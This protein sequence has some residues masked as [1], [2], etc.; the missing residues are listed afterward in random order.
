MAYQPSA[1]GYPGAPGAYPQPYGAPYGH[2]GGAPQQYGPPPGYPQAGP[3]AYY[4]AAPAPPQPGYPAQPGYAPAPGYPMQQPQPYGYPPPQQYAPQPY[5][6]PPYQA[7]PAQA[8]G[9]PMGARRLPTPCQG[10]WAGLAVCRAALPVRAGLMHAAFRMGLGWHRALSQQT[11][12]RAAPGRG[13]MVLQP[14]EN[15]AGQAMISHK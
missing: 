6:A 2:P 13:C 8:Y 5:G 14:A 3:Q 1:P 7:A 12:R 4:G 11:C 10:P 15:W 9:P